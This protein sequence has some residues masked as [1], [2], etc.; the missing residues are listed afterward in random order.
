MTSACPATISA[1]VRSSASPAPIIASRH[2]APGLHEPAR[3]SGDNSRSLAAVCRLFAERRLV[4]DHQQRRQALGVDQPEDLDVV[5]GALAPAGN[6]KRPLRLREQAMIA[7]DVLVRGLALAFAL[8]A[9]L[10]GPF[11]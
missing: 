11:L 7:Q 9:L 8:P 2:P 4:E 6:L 10:L 1:V 3:M 5:A